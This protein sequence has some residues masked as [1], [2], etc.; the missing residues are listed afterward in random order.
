MQIL[1][2]K[3]QGVVYARNRGFNAA[4]GDILARIDA[5]TVLPNGWLER[6]QKSFM[7]NTCAAQTGEPRFNDVLFP[8]VINAT[9]VMFYQHFQKAL[10]GSWTLWGAN[11]AIRRSVWQKVRATTTTKP[12]VDE[13]IDLS[14]CVTSA[15]YRIG[16]NLLPVGASFMRANLEYVHSVKYIVSWPKDYIHHRMF[17]R[18]GLI[19]ILVVFA[20]IA[21]IPFGPLM[22]YMGN[23]FRLAE[24]EY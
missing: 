6:V 14:F 21:V 20:A 7:G 17:L 23:A 16:L 12:G 1:H 10:T 18:A 8:K 19:G 11:M 13:D 5:D 22:T 4:K 3:H 2:E 9:Q 24:S 15:G